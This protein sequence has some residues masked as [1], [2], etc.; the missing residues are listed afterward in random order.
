MSITLAKLISK[1]EFSRLSSVDNSVALA[2]LSKRLS[3]NVFLLWLIFYTAQYNYFLTLIVWYFYST[4]FQFW[5]YTGLGHEALHGRVFSSKS[6]NR[7]LFILCSALTW[8]NS[9]MFADSHAVHHRSTFST[10]DYEANSETRWGFWYIFGYSLIDIPAIGRRVYFTLVNSFG[11]YPN[12]SRLSLKY[13]RAARLNLVVNLI[14]YTAFYSITQDFVVTALAA[15]APFSCTLLSKI[16]AKAQHHN[17]SKFSS[18][19]PLKFSRT[20]KLPAWLSFLYANMNYHAEHHL[21]PAIPYYNLPDFH[22]LLA[23]KGLIQSQS[24][25]NFLRSTLNNRGLLS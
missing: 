19:G 9:A 13:V 24:L 10:E 1:E 16:L 22:N 12:F 18:Q 6:A 17:L 5:G 20:L 14:I 23:G 2:D 21:A 7:L 15:A 25:Q 3:L 11:Y 8:N 4:Q